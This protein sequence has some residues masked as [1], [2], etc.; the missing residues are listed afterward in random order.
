[1]G[2]MRQVV[3]Q[4]ECAWKGAATEDIE[5]QSMFSKGAPYVTTYID[6]PIQCSDHRILHNLY[7]AGGELR[8]AQDNRR[9]SGANLPLCEHRLD[10]M[11]L[12]QSTS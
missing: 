3:D 6:G 8:T 12:L 5:L 9:R 11:L 2:Q 7:Y 1:M 10:Q 4:V